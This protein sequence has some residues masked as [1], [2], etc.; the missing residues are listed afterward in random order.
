MDN[1]TVIL[2]FRQNAS[3]PNEG[4]LETI[5]SY[6]LKPDA[7]YEGLWTIGERETVIFPTGDA[8]ELYA[9]VHT[10]CNHVHL[11]SGAKRIVSWNAASNVDLMFLL[12]SG[13]EAYLSIN[14]HGKLA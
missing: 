9:E 11:Y 10:D 4:P 6:P 13:Q 12:P 1:P 8:L 2:R 3:T 14:V 7:W 5:A